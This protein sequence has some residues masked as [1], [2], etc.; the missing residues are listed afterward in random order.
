MQAIKFFVAMALVA[1]LGWAAPLFTDWW[2]FAITSFLVAAFIP[3]K[4]WQAF[5][6]GFAGIFLLWFMMEM[7]KDM[8]NN[9]I[10]S[11]RIAE[12]LGLH[13]DYFVLMLVSSLLAGIISGLAALSGCVAFKRKKATKGI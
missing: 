12:L 10:L 6:A 3:L 1:L 13:G 4:A 9:H 2:T 8:A 5:F 7:L 11:T